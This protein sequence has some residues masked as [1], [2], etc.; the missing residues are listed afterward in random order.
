MSVERREKLLGQHSLALLRPAPDVIEIARPGGSCWRPDV[1]VYQAIARALE[2]TPGRV[3]ELLRL[4]GMP[5]DHAVRPVELVGVLVGTGLAG[6][7]REP[8]AAERTGADRLNALLDVEEDLA[9]SRGATLATPATRSGITLSSASF[10]LYS[11]LR[12]GGSPDAEALAAQFIRRCR[13]AG[14]HPIV[15]GKQ[16]ESDAE[17]Q[18]AVT[19]DY[20]T[21]IDRIVPIW[22]MIGLV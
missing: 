10:A 15:D 21:K 16:L 4:D 13:D 6:L 9:L 7:F 12:R 19:K 3:D 20:A 2:S 18:V 14:G 17:A 11:V 8:T 1:T 22:R 5:R